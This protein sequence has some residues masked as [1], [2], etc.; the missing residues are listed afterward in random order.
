[1]KNNKIVHFE[2][3]V[4]RLEEAE[5]M[6]VFKCVSLWTCLYTSL[7]FWLSPEFLCHVIDG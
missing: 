7:L 3:V 2:P 4:K 5:V 1:M 6:F